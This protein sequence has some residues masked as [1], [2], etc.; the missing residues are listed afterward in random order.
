MFHQIAGEQDQ[1][2]NKFHNVD[3][4]NEMLKKAFCKSDSGV[5][6]D[7]NIIRIKTD[8]KCL[9]YDQANKL[10]HENALRLPTLEELQNSGIIESDDMDFFA[11]V[12][13]PD[14]KPDAVQLGKGNETVKER[15]WSHID[16]L[17]EAKWLNNNEPK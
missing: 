3:Q 6:S 12:Q 14:N 17:G 15:F 4:Q 10:A 9:N 5:T 16:K 13:R 7:I 1:I 2:I 11:F 8:D